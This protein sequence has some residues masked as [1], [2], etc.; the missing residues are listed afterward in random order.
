MSKAT[1]WDQF[2]DPEYED[3]VKAAMPK[4]SVKKMIKVGK[5]AKRAE[6]KMNEVGYLGHLVYF[7]WDLTVWPNRGVIG[8]ILF[9]GTI[10]LKVKHVI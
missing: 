2:E 10:A 5:K 7:L 8:Y 9:A 3:A 4:G 1:T 6:R